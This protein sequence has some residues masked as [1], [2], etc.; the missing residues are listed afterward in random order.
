MAERRSP[1]QERAVETRERILDTAAHLFASRGVAGTSTNRIAEQAGISIGALYRY[2]SDKHQIVEVL[3]GR[4]MAELEKEFT[5]SVLSSLTLPTEEGITQ[6]LRLV[7]S[8]L[9][10]RRG[11]VLALMGPVAPD[12]EVLG[13]FE[14]RL[15]VITRAYL[16]H[17]GGPQSEADLD[18]RAYLMVTVGLATCVRIA[19]QAPRNLD[20]DAL[21]SE[22][23]RMLATWIQTAA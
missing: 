1:R 4:L 13:T 7:T 2:F 18:V 5:S 10:E 16:L 8:A 23:G 9:A 3:R 17:V 6:G 19:L 12:Q 20:R 22:V 11:L 14:S 21:V 15:L